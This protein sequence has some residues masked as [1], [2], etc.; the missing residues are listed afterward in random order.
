[1]AV[2]ALT[3]LVD[4]HRRI[5]SPRVERRDVVRDNHIV[6]VSPGP[7]SDAIAR[8]RGLIAIRRIAFDAQIR[9]PCSPTFSDRGSE[10]LTRGVS[11]RQTAA[12]VALVTKKLMPVAELADIVDSSPLPQPAASKKT[13][14]T[15]ARFIFSPTF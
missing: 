15:R 10:P 14:S 11:S 2:D 4:E 1:L 8:V 5:T 6:R 3:A 13:D 9:A 12:L 7:G